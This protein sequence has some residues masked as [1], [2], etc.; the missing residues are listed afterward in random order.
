MLISQLCYESARARL[1]IRHV[2]CQA[3]E[4]GRKSFA[5]RVG[6]QRERAATAQGFV[7]EKVERAQ[8]W[9][10][11]TFDRAVTDTLEVFFHAR[12]RY[13]AH[14]QR[15][16]LIAQC[17]QPDI[18]RV[19]FIARARVRA[20]FHGICKGGVERY[21]LPNLGALNFLLHESLG[22]GGTLSLMTDAQGKTFSTALL[23]MEIDVP[24]DEARAL[25]LVG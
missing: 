13:L 15:I 11:K 23:R 17:D 20:H 22:G 3:Q 6:H 8:V 25:G 7:Q 2:N 12:R 16:V 19:A 24:D 18:G 10:L 5:L 1:F 4:R 9:Q 14:E 21:E